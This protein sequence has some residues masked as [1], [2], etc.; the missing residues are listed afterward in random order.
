VRWRE[1]GARRGRTFDRQKDADR[2]ATE[3]R[4]RQQVAGVVR[5]DQGQQTLAEFVETY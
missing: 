2:F 5:I 3:L 4:R 1:S